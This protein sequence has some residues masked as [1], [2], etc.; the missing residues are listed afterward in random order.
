MPSPGP[1]G[2]RS[3]P[4]CP[5]RPDCTRQAQGRTINKDGYY[6]VVLRQVRKQQEPANR[7][8]LRQRKRIA[9]LPFA[10]LKQLMGFRRWTVRGLDNVRAQWNLL[11]T[12]LNLKILHGCWKKGQLNMT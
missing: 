9:E 8:L 3:S 5:S 1:S 4:A 6:E 2:P 12:A 10:W 7:A 11:C